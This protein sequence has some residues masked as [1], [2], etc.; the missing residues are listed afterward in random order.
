MNPSFMAP[1]YTTSLGHKLIFSGLVMIG[2]GT[3]ILK[4]I[5]AFKG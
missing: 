1:L 2:F 3:L 5:V 4:R